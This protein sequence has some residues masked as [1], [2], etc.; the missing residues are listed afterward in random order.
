[1]VV[2]VWQEHIREVDQGWTVHHVN[3]KRCIIDKH[4]YGYFPF[5]QEHHLL[6]FCSRSENL[7]LLVE[8]LDFHAVV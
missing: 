3:C 8:F 4:I 2:V 7:E 5:D 1:M 6:L